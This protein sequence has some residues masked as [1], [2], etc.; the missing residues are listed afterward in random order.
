MQADIVAMLGEPAVK[1]MF[2]PLGVAVAGSTPA[3]LA[4]RAL[5][6]AELWGP[7]IKAANIKGE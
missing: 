7:V 4:A 3:E 6:D 5:A 1:A 2:E